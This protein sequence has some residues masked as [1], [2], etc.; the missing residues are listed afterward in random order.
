MYLPG[1]LSKTGLKT[2]TES[3]TSPG[4]TTSEMSLSSM[5]TMSPNRVM[6]EN[7]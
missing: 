1:V 3:G 7:L 2:F 5:T 6:G 4:L